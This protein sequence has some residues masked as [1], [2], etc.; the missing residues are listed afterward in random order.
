MDK[1]ILNY[2]N[3][4]NK[5]VVLLCSGGL[6][7]C[8]CAH[9]LTWSGFIIRGVFVDYGQSALKKEWEKTKALSKSLGFKVT[10]V[11]IDIPWI[12]DLPI[13]GGEVTEDGEIHIQRKE[14]DPDCYIPLRNHI[15]ISLAGSLAEKL[16]FPYICTGIAGWQDILGRPKYGYTDAHR[17]FADSL[18]YSLNEGSVFYHQDHRKFKILT[19]LVSKS[20]AEII[21]LGEEICA[22][23]SLSWTCY[24]GGEKPCGKC[25]SCIDRA[26]GFRA[27]CLEDP[28]E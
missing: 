4:P 16:K 3:L 1:E 2:V 17:K 11:K 6:D 22:D 14:A 10:R 13:V 27:N 21:Q 9:L 23:F 25:P 24:N 18:E 15:L 8:V 28:L 26:N 7:S 20:K 12:K 5:R 19:P